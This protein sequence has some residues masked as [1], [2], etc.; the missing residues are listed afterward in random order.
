MF[1]LVAEATH[2]NDAVNGSTTVVISDNDGMW[3]G[4]VRT[5]NVSNV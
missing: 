3:D 5:S 2:V 1:T 4:N